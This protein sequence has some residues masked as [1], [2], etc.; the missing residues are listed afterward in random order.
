MVMHSFIVL[1]RGINVGGH[2]KVPMAELRDLLSKSGFQNI[3]TYIQT[4]NIALKTTIADPLQV[5]KTIHDAIASHFEFD[6]SVMAKKAS[7]IQRIFSNCPFPEE[8]GPFQSVCPRY[9]QSNQWNGLQ[10]L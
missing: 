10:V 5:E 3:K 7:D 8:K 9:Q 1:L 6:V 2:K 4:G